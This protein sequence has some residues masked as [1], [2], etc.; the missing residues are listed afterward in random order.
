MAQINLTAIAATLWPRIQL[1]RLKGC[2]YLCWQRSRQ[3]RALAMLSEHELRDLGLT[4]ED[5]R[6]EIQ[7]P[8]WR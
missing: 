5:V 8:S 1:T 2:L 3:R 7:R 6:L 4:P